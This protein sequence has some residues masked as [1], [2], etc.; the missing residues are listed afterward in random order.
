MRIKICGIRTYDEA[1]A[2]IEAGADILGFNFYPQSP[3]YIAPGD[4]LKLAVRLQA[5]LRE[6]MA[7]IT[8]VGV[9][10]NANPQYAHALTADCL[11]DR[12]Q[13]SG[14]EPP[15]DLEILGERSYKVLR[16]PDETALEDAVRLYPKRV[17][18]PA[19]MIDTYL[20]GQY[21]GTGQPADWGMIRRFAEK[22]PIILAGGLRADNVAEAIR[23][24]HPWGVDVASGV[25]SAP[26]VKDLEK[27]RAFIRAVKECEEQELT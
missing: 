24:V 2:I 14:D 13:L 15:G 6:E 26:G 4:A 22:E 16:P 7:N 17:L 21:G 11:L 18:A 9:F 10:V 3:R 5:T 27:V 19:W 12:I 25:E 23:L 8:L 1:M 20:P